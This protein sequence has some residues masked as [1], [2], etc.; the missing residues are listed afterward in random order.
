MSTTTSTNNQELGGSPN[1]A[2]SNSNAIVSQMVPSYVDYSTIIMDAYNSYVDYSTKNQ[3]LMLSKIDFLVSFIERTNGRC[4]CDCHYHTEIYHF[5]RW[6]KAANASC[7]ND[8]LSGFMASTTVFEIT[9]HTTLATWKNTALFDAVLYNQL[10]IVKYLIKKGAN[11]NAY[12][13]NELST[14]QQA[15]FGKS[16]FKGEERQVSIALVKILLD[17]GAELY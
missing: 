3:I 4:Q 17:A 9:D 11:V 14:L 7:L 13:L 2:Q 6:L 8:F 1:M 5:F 12:N 10:H 16:D 15:C